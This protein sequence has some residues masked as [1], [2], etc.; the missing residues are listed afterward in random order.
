M[1]G[2]KRNVILNISW[3]FIGVGITA[4]LGI[5]N[6]KVF[7]QILGTELLGVNNLFSNI[8]TLFSFADLGVGTAIMFALYKPIAQNN[9]KYI[10][11]LLY[12]YNKIYFFIIFIIFIVG[13]C[14]VPFIKYLDTDI[15]LNNLYIYYGIILANSIIG[16]FFAFRESY[17]VALQKER[18]LT[19]L[20]TIGSII[21][22][23]VQIILINVFSDFFFYLI[24]VLFVSILRKILVNIIVIKKYPETILKNVEP[25]SKNDKREIIKKSY[26]LL[27]HKIGNLCISQTDSIIVSYMI[28]VNTWGLMANYLMIK[29]LIA[30]ITT[31]VYDSILPS[32][33]ELTA[34]RKPDYQLKIFK[35]YDFINAWG[36][37]FLFVSLSCLSSPFINYVFGDKYVIDDFIIFNFYFSFFVQG[38]TCPVA[39]LREATGSFDKDKWYTVIGAVI[40]LITSIIFVKI[41]GVAGVY[42]GTS[43]AMLFIFIA[44]SIIIFDTDNIYN[45]SYKSYFIRTIKYVFLALVECR[46]TFFLCNVISD[47]LAGS[48]Y[49]LSILVLVACIVPN[50][51]HIM[52][53]INSSELL[54]VRKI[55]L[56]R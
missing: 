21:T 39:V 28:N 47:S 27:I 6:R 56:K 31:K 46:V 37:T 33:G 8:L 55:I 40:N 44:R 45:Y 32:M 1:S 24:T 22:L 35:T 2:R 50:F 19:F 18:V 11:S 26:A 54:I 29:N 15:P 49:E 17:L 14:F 3:A 12:F 48:I 23:L 42:V 38:L 51:M 16:Y 30:G 5:I 7:L 4:I 25:L 9:I 13:V 53:N 52:I 34:T 43:L 10:K 36:Y 20:N 41:Y